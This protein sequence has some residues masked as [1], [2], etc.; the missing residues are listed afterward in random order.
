MFF[1]EKHR[2]KTS[3]TSTKNIENINQKHRKH[4]EFHIFPEQAEFDQLQSRVEASAEY[5][6]NL[7]ET[8]LATKYKKGDWIKYVAL[9]SEDDPDL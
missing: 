5:L 7:I 2:V 4:R 1:R 6:R 3:K 8:E 9:K